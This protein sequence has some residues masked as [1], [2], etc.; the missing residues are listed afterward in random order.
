M[1][2]LAKRALL[3]AVSN[4]ADVAA[5]AEA[6]KTTSY[7]TLAAMRAAGRHYEDIIAEL[8]EKGSAL[9]PL[10]YR[11]W[12]VI[13]FAWAIPNHD[14]IQYLCKQS[15]I[16]EVGAGSG[17]W[18]HRIAAE[19]GQIAATDPRF[20]DTQAKALDIV[21]P[22]PWCVIH[23]IPSQFVSFPPGAT[24]FIC[25][26]GYMEKWPA[27][28]LQRYPGTDVIYV[29]D[30]SLCADDGFHE[31][32]D[33]DWDIEAVIEIPQFMKIRDRLIHYRRKR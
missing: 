3:A 2:S 19:G 16:V 12:F 31:M 13:Y 8:T 33:A 26:P 20:W 15:P 18:A 23:K 17:Y 9:L 11:D 4:T 32:L 6:Q 25:W 7:E 24:L 22:E 5:Y 21:Y 29:G 14:A 27:K 28:L 30:D 1:N 10:A